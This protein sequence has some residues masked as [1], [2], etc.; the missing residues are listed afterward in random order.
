MKSGPLHKTTLRS[1][2]FQFLFP[3]SMK[4]YLLYAEKQ[5]PVHQWKFIQS[6]KLLNFG[7]AIIIKLVKVGRCLQ[8]WSCLF[9]NQPRVF[10]FFYLCMYFF[11]TKLLNFG[12]KAQSV[13]MTTSVQDFFKNKLDTNHRQAARQSRIPTFKRFVFLKLKLEQTAALINF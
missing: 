3:N 12:E 7:T 10:K 13:S 6:G 5:F 8:R 1:H 9:E 4:I 11:P 2:H